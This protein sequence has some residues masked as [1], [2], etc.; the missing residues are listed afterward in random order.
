MEKIDN[1]LKLTQSLKNQLLVVEKTLAV[2]SKNL[3]PNRL[4][5]IGQTATKDAFELISSITNSINAMA[6]RPAGPQIAISNFMDQ[7]YLKQKEWEENL[8]LKLLIPQ[9]IKDVN[10]SIGVNPIE[11]CNFAEKFIENSAIT[12]A[13]AIE[14]TIKSSENF[15]ISIHDNGEGTTPV[16]SNE[17]QELISNFKSIGVE[18]KIS[19]I[20]GIGSG[21]ICIIRPTL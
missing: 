16:S 19:S 3:P 18:A 14:F 20:E 11:F 15:V 12:G 6:T 9:N 10:K 4:T 13:S 1:L 5:E 2:Y 7:L 21:L 8:N 17:F